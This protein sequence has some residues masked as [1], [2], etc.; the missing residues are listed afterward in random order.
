[1]SY[2]KHDLEYSE[3]LIDLIYSNTDTP[4]IKLAP[5]KFEARNM[6][7]GRV[8][9]YAFKAPPGWFWE[10]RVDEEVFVELSRQ[11][12]RGCKIILKTAKEAGKGFVEFRVE[13]NEFLMDGTAVGVVDRE[14]KDFDCPELKLELPNRVS[15]WTDFAPLF[16]HWI[17]N[18]RK[19]GADA[20]GVA[21]KARGAVPPVL[22][23]E[24]VVVKA[25]SEASPEIQIEWTPPSVEIREPEFGSAHK[26][27]LIEQFMPPSVWL[28]KPYP[29]VALL[30]G[31]EYYFPMGIDM[32]IGV[33]RFKAYIAPDLTLT[34]TFLRRL[35]LLKPLTK[36]Y[37]METARIYWPDKS[38]TAGGVEDVLRR[39][40]YDTSKLLA[41][42]DELVKEGKLVRSKVG[43]EAFYRIAGVEVK[44]KPLTEEVVLSKIR[45]LCQA[46]DT[47]AIGYQ[48]LECVLAPEYQISPLHDILK[49]LREKGLVE[50]KPWPSK[51]KGPYAVDMRGYWAIKE[52]K[53][54]EAVKKAEEVKLKPL[55]KEVVLSAI[56]KL[57][58]EVKENVKYD[59]VQKRLMDEGY[60]TAELSRFI[61]EL[62]KVD[63]AIRI[64]LDGRIISK[65]YEE[66]VKPKPPPVP[67]EF[68]R[69]RFKRDMP[70]FMGKHAEMYG[71]FK[72]GE[73]A[74]IPIMF[75]EA[76]EKATYVEVL[77]RG[78]P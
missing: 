69:V 74:V 11:D 77:A 3:K 52:T 49:R 32:E 48:E 53:P 78:G 38:F 8:T 34:D 27:H 60:D 51:R 44:Y 65:A 37:I 17:V 63:K 28:R 67:P 21:C 71:P 54:E 72:A 26:L 30:F 58:D 59:D 31:K 76:F 61:D 73:E 22:A 57:N 29:Y 47:D 19:A 10:Y 14:R 4:I 68:A 15:G 7:A 23:R 16:K 66:K 35:N 18:A 40:G 43:W 5:L 1:L 41:L 33:A 24:T 45:E 75:A 9:A 50:T 46:W 13:G 12:R 39:E 70:R 20:V 36:E 25:F 64:T 2:F 55:T 56:E 62:W 42:L 6:D